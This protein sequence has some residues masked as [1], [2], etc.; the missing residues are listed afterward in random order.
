M[1]AQESCDFRS[2]V[3]VYCCGKE[4]STFIDSACVVVMGVVITARETEKRIG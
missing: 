4:H 2:L 1:S 3:V